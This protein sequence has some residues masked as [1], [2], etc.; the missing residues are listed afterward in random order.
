MRI[1][2]LLNNLTAIFIVHRAAYLLLDPNSK[3]KRTIDPS[4]HRGL[5]TT[6]YSKLKQLLA[7]K[8][9]LEHL[10]ES[11]HQTT[12]PAYQS[13]FESPNLEVIYRLA[14]DSAIDTLSY[15]SF[16]ILYPAVLQS[17]N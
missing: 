16:V 17:F 3:K 14:M 6:S 7:G 11:Q 1:S 4:K 15:S 8:I 5:S 10:A 12:A 2:R 13:Q 9:S